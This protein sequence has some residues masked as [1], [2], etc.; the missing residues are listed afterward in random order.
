MQL[1]SKF[2]VS[3][4]HAMIMGKKTKRPRTR[5]EEEKSVPSFQQACVKE[6]PVP[7]LENQA[8]SRAEG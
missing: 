1:T 3:K 8:D 7:A 4:H 5:K 6:E 2:Y